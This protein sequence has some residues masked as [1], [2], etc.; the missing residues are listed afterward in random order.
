MVAGSSIARKDRSNQDLSK[1][2][3]SYGGFRFDVNTN[4]KKVNVKK[5][6]EIFLNSIFS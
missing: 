2:L 1:T 5:D 6:L 3:F 4:R